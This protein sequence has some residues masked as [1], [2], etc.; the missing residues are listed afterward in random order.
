MITINGIEFDELNLKDNQVVNKRWMVVNDSVDNTEI[1][2][3][4]LLLADKDFDLIESFGYLKELKDDENAIWIAYENGIIF[5]YEYI[6]GD[7]NGYKEFDSID[8]A[9]KWCENHSKEKLHDLFMK[10]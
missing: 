3:K 9:M 6:N 5:A 2:V 4:F 7:F 8:E 1:S 10:Q